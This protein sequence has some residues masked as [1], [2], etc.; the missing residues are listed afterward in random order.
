MKKLQNVLK[1]AGTI[2]VFLLIVFYSLSLI[3]I[4]N[5]PNFG[6]SFLI[7]LIC[8]ILVINF[9]KL[10][11]VILNLL[12]FIFQKNGIFIT[13][14]GGIGL[15]VVI[16]LNFTSQFDLQIPTG[17]AI[18]LTLTYVF[19]LQITAAEG[20]IEAMTETEIKNKNLFY[21]FLFVIC[22]SGLDLIAT[23]GT[24]MLLGKTIFPITLVYKPVFYEIF[25]LFYLTPILIGF[26]RKIITE[27]KRRKLLILE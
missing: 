22:F 3:G 14:F 6:S 19:G 20:K 17:I 13:I 5:Y 23:C 11:N 4:I 15:I 16:S 9:T 10:K 8:T 26:I 18:L 24:F 21:I 27:E 2:I 7:T 25:L 1:I 12:K